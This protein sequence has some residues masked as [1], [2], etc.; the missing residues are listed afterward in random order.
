MEY[1]LISFYFVH[2]LN[3]T[4]HL[5]LSIFILWASVFS[6]TKSNLFRRVLCPRNQKCTER[7][8][9]KI[10]PPVP[11]PPKCKQWKTTSSFSSSYS[12]TILYS[13][14]RIIS[15]NTEVKR[16]REQQQ[17][18]V[19]N[20]ASLKRGTTF[21]LHI[22]GRFSKDWLEKYRTAKSIQSMWA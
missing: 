8:H 19:D 4:L 20:F 17:C 1:P 12:D 10:I 7:I 3:K 9:S 2:W 5:L 18:P 13:S 6:I 15:N 11:A 14:K 21:F 16:E 22:E